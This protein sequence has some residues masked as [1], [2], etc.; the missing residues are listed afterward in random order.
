MNDSIVSSRDSMLVADSLRRVAALD[1]MKGYTIYADSTQWAKDTLKTDTTPYS[2]SSLDAPVV[3]TASDSITFDMFESRANLYGNSQVDYQ[4]LAL[5]ADEI[6]ISL[7]SSLVHAAGRKDS[8]GEM[9]GK[10]LF[11]QGDEEYE[12][13]RISY[14]FKTRKAFIT[15]VYTK[16]G[17][18]FMT[19]N[20]S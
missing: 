10:P 7:D 11:K 16:Q 20:E 4:N 15:N 17:V 3:Y 8:L 2:K 19:T 13:D 12:P 1:S 14:N 6:T 9:I 5:T 18:G